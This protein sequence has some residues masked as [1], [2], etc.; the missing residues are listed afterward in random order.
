LWKSTS[1][2]VDFIAQ[3]ISSYGLSRHGKRLTK[4]DLHK[5]DASY[6][7]L[8]VLEIGGSAISGWLQDGAVLDSA[9]RTIGGRYE[10]TY[11]GLTDDLE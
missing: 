8:Q 2:F 7:P 9:F 3:G 10:W 4:L 6:E 11:Q 5:E 1:Q